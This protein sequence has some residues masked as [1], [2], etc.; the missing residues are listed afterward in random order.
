MN[1]SS[2]SRYVAATL[3]TLTVAGCTMNKQ[4][5]PSLTGPSEFGQAITVS[6]TPDVITQDGASSSVVTVTA[7]G[8]NGSPLPNLTLRAEILVNG[9]ST[10][11]G[12][13]SA[14]NVVTD[15]NGRATIVYTAPGTPIG[16]V[17]ESYSL[18][19]IAVTPVGTDFG[20]AT[21]RLTTVRLVPPP[22]T[23]VVPPADGLLPAF[24]FTP[25]APVDNENVGFDA[26]TSQA[27]AATP[28]AQ[29]QWAFGDGGSASGI[30]ATHSYASPGQYTVTLTVVET[31]GR[32]RS[33][34]R[35]INV[36]VGAN[37]P[38]AVFNFSPT[39]PAACQNVFFNASGSTAS[40]GRR[41]VGYRWVFGDGTTSNEGPTTTKRYTN[42]TNTTYVVTLTVTDDVG[43]TATVQQTVPVI[44]AASPCS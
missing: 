21:T 19:N 18:V 32:S 11:F 26:S 25:P 44:P 12:R 28:I 33:T 27:P 5:A 16:A 38:T 29:Y 24:T 35:T 4:E 6:V 36:S 7:R 42:T 9:V 1:Q 17:V 41:I 15:G 20:N 30:T 10:D 2:L 14:R 3:V 43:R 34:S 22:G 40:Q 8:P 23:I 31:L 13:L 39:A 37:V